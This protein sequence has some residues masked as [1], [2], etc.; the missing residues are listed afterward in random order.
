[1]EAPSSILRGDACLSQSG[2][3]PH[4]RMH[5]RSNSLRSESLGPGPAAPVVI[6]LVSQ[7]NLLLLH[8]LH[9]QSLLLLQPFPV[10]LHLLPVVLLL[11]E[12]QVL[13]LLLVSL[14]LLLQQ[15]LLLVNLL[16]L[17]APNIRLRHNDGLLWEG[18]A[19]KM[20]GGVVLAILAN[21]AEE[22][23]APH[24]GAERPRRCTEKQTRGSFDDSGIFR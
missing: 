9:S 7:Q 20:N 12:P 8:L 18:L 24:E 3:G 10:R 13:L 2:Y 4:A 21:F 17:L 5:V 1:M 15:Q 16:L 6:L 22:V 19:A 11:L 23:D 14:L